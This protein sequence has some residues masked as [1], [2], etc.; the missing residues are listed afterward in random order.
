MHSKLGRTG[1][2]QITGFEG[3]IMG[4]AEYLTGCNQLLI[5]PRELD[6]DGNRRSGEW[7]DESRIGLVALLPIV[8]LDVAEVKENP[9]C[10]ERSAPVM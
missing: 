8:T 9:G 6:K 1:R 4:R 3:V 2:D 7:F 5:A 10:D